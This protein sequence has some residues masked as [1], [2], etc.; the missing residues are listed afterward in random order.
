MGWLLSK[1][2]MLSEWSNNCSSILGTVTYLNGSDKCSKSQLGGSRQILNGSEHSSSLSAGSYPSGGG[3][4][5]NEDDDDE[6]SRD[7]SDGYHFPPRNQA[8]V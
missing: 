2:K 1:K 4:G 3:A 5:D 8:P 6:S 7:P